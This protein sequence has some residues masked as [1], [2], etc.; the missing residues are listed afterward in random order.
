[1]SQLSYDVAAKAA[2]ASKDYC[3]ALLYLES[4]VAAADTEATRK[5]RRQGGVAWSLR[6]CK[7]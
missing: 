5:G 6:I 1:M 7:V 2:M 4:Y 3:R